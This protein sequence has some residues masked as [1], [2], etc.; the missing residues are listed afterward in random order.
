M[1]HVIAVEPLE[2][3]SVRMTLSDGTIVVRGLSAPLS[4]VGTRRSRISCQKS[5]WRTLGA[6][7]HAFAAGSHQPRAWLGT[8]D[9]RWVLF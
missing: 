2:G 1:L 6:I 7:G 3:R 4:G 9:A 5:D 8:R